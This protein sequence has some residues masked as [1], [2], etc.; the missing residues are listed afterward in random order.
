MVERAAQPETRVEH[1]RYQGETGRVLDCLVLSEADP[2][3][4]FV[5][6]AIVDLT[7]ALQRV[8]TTEV[9]PNRAG[10]VV[11]VVSSSGVHES[12]ALAAVRGL[13]LSLAEELGVQGRLNLVV[14]GDASATALQDTLA[15]LTSPSGAYV[16]AA[17]LVLHGPAP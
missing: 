10:V 13:V 5:V 14:T 15:F 11:I 7:S 3:G 17:T 8:F 2:T 12:P 16:T 9:S 6:S 4:E 1:R